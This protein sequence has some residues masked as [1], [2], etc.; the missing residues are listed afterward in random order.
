[1][2]YMHS[3]LTENPTMRSLLVHQHPSVGSGERGSA[4]PPDFDRLRRS[5]LAVSSA[6]A[7]SRHAIQG[8]VGRG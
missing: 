4:E 1:M 8:E 7:S 6:A 2:L 3:Y 5:R